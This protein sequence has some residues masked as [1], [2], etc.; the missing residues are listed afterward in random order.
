MRY[1]FGDSA[2]YTGNDNQDDR[3]SGCNIA[4]KYIYE[5]DEK[6]RYVKKVNPYHDE[7]NYDYFYKGN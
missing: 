6:G 4:D 2:V 5:E 1:L 3:P 7:E